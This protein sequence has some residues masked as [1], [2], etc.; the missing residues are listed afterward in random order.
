[1]TIIT[2]GSMKIWQ[3]EFNKITMKFSC[4]L[5]FNCLSLLECRPDHH[6]DVGV[7]A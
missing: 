5:G 2:D 1:M 6:S 7:V 4:Q 3:S